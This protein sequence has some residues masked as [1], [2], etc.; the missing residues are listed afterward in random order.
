MNAA[1]ADWWHDVIGVNPLPRDGKLKKPSVNWEKYQTQPVP[2]WEF[3]QW[4]LQDKYKD[5]ILIT[6]GPVWF[7]EDKKNYYLVVIDW[8]K[9]L[10]ITEL[11]E[12]RPL[13]LAKQRFMIEQRKNA[14]DR[15]HMFFYS[16]IEFP[17]KRSDSVLG[18]EIK[19]VKDLV[20]VWPS[21]HETGYQ[22]ESVGKPE[23]PTLSLEE[24]RR[25]MQHINEICYKHNIPYLE[26][27]TS[28]ERFKPMI[29]RLV[30]FDTSIRIPH[31]ERHKTLIPIAN[32]ILF[33]HLGKT[34]KSEEQLKNFFI[35]INS[36]LCD[37][38][39]VPESELMGIWDSA[40]K[41]VSKHKSD[42]DGE[43]D[44]RENIIEEATESIIS[45]YNILTLEET[46]DILYYNKDSGVYVS[47]GEVLIEKE[48]EELFNYD[49]SNKSLSEIKGHVM[50][51]TYRSMSEFDTDL[52]IINMKNGLYNIRT[53]EFKE[54]SPDYLSRNQCNVVYNQ[55]LKPKLFG[56]YL[57]EV[58][59]PT[60]IRTVIEL[61]AYT[62][63]RDNPFEVIT[64]L[65]GTGLNGK[66]VFTSLLTAMHG[67]KNVSN[68]PLSAMLKDIYALSDLENKNVNI[69]TE[70]SSATIHDTAILKKITGR[71]P[72]RIQ[73]KNQRAYD[74]LL[75]AKPFFSGNELPHSEDDT[76]A[77]HRRNVIINFPNLFEGEHAD[78]KLT[79]KLT[80]QEEMSGIFN[81]LM[82][83]LRR[84]LD[85]GIFLTEKTIQQRRERYDLLLNPVK[86][87]LVEAV[88]E[89]SIVTDKI[90]KE[91]LY[92]AY[93]IFCKRKKL[94]IESKEKFGRL[95][96][97]QGYES[98][99]IDV[100]LGHNKRK[101]G[102]SGIRLVDNYHIQTELTTTGMGDSFV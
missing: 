20:C 27:D 101:H 77:Y 73:R 41:Y 86:H 39:G 61:M 5:G 71:Q 52:N 42:E 76:D 16:P 3:E 24:V 50:R 6:P 8:D 22:Y 43:E 49:L 96:K 29:K 46:K 7:R 23:P 26:K 38:E 1:A 57:S 12:G 17:R 47:G 14:L 21:V 75:H 36:E 31:H 2:Q 81:V 89:D 67:L 62:F 34:G 87:F 25:L 74:A 66:S 90:S 53:G 78:P 72:I 97:A 79:E 54:H 83:V 19:G 64:I 15:G 94:I 4:K 51:K 56:K 13:D 100:G 92:Q 9:E 11:L 59:Y 48:A 88:A 69:D 45:K 102:W 93:S 18:L 55:K 63:Y 82:N 91:D 44:E 30:I 70:L 98:C 95:I 33:N 84:V 99:R 68:V 85:K 32:S 37:P 10:G 35:K 40:V 65:F 28:L 80:T 58:L 60:E